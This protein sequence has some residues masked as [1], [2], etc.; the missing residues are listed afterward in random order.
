MVIF[1]QKFIIFNIENKVNM[2]VIMKKHFFLLAAA[3][4]AMF[5]FSACSDDNGD[6]NPSS[7]STGNEVQDIKACDMSASMS[8]C[9]EGYGP[10]YQDIQELEEE[11]ARGGG[12]IKSKC[13]DAALTCP[14]PTDED[15][16]TETYYIYGPAT[17]GLGGQ[18]PDDPEDILDLLPEPS[19][20]KIACNYLQ[21][22]VAGGYCWDISISN[23]AELTL[24]TNYCTSGELGTLGPGSIVDKCPDDADLEC[25]DGKGK[26]YFYGAMATAMETRYG[27]CP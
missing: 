8:I 12:T 23:I 14:F 25:P 19:Q 11:C 7:S 24:N 4:V 6:E 15:G 17:A 21:L 10:G 27:G 9:I 5:S 2:E 26:D 22:P 13:P 3:L 1:S 16:D 18:C 20:T